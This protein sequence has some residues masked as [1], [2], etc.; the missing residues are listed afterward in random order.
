LPVSSSLSDSRRLLFVALAA[1]VA[2]IALAACSATGTLI[3]LA[4]TDTY[5]RTL[6]IAYGPLPRQRLDIFALAATPP[7]AGWPVV[8]FFYGGNWDPAAIAVPESSSVKRS[9]SAACSLS[10]PT[11]ASIPK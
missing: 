6:D 2:T 7:V 3:A 9:P 8:V 1:A 5:H 11:I 4:R 10:S